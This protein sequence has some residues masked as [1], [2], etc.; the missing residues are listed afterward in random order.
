MK[1]IQVILSCLLPLILAS[2][3]QVS[4]TPQ[5]T[6]SAS[7]ASDVKPESKIKTAWTVSA[8][9]VNPMDKVSTQFVSTGYIVRLVLCF[10]NGK[11]C[12]HGSVPVFVTS[13]CWVDGNDAGSYRRRI[14]VKFDDDKPISENWGIS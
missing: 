14:R 7:A 3:S 8:P 11:P 5:P 6:A 1:P 4:N 2:C 10:E 12:G 13:P 9:N